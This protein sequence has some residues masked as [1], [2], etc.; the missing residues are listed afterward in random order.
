M[1]FFNRY[2]LIWGSISK[3]ANIFW[4]ILS[5]TVLTTVYVKKRYKKFS[6][7]WNLKRTTHSAQN[8]LLRKLNLKFYVIFNM[9]SVVYA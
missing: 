1:D 9:I 8:S 3:T 5:S 6:W 7:K 4:D 2:P